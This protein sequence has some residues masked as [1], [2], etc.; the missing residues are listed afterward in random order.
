MAN[1]FFGE[2]YEDD[3][4][5]DLGEDIWRLKRHVMVFF[6]I[7]RISV[8]CSLGLLVLGAIFNLF[9]A[10][11]IGWIL[12]MA[13]LLFETFHYKFFY[14]YTYR[15]RRFA[16]L[17][18]SGKIRVILLYSYYLIYMFIAGLYELFLQRSP[19]EAFNWYWLVGYLL[20]VSTLFTTPKFWNFKYKIHTHY[21]FLME[22]ENLKLKK[23]DS[24]RRKFLYSLANESYRKKK[25]E[26]AL[27]RYEELIEFYPDN[28][29]FWYKR[30]LV[31]NDLKLY[32][33]ALDC[34]QEVLEL[35]S[36]SKSKISTMLYKKGNEMYETRQYL[37]ALEY[38]NQGTSLF[39]EEARF[40]YFRGTMFYN[41][42]Q[43]KEALSDFDEAIYLKPNYKA[44]L[45]F[46]KTTF[47]KLDPRTVRR[48]MDMPQR[49]RARAVTSKERAI[50]WFLTDN[51]GKAFTSASLV[52]RIKREGL[53]RDIESILNHLVEDNK[54]NRVEKDNTLF[55]SI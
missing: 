21:G 26:E 41:L 6:Q 54:I 1:N 50:I 33:E 22:K 16:L 11:L 55:Y 20:L 8:L 29:V 19:P 35:A 47:V 38:Y 40:W 31:L 37:K 28:N 2:D 45:F 36:Y 49:Y 14:Y 15:G 27:D 46:R 43:F 48:K 51:E 25:Y 52:K 30:G 3:Y 53:S 17:S 18:K 10:K 34:F 12:F 32:S 42:K 9:P 24:E 4:G 39:P 13:S 44:A 5:E 7:M 23:E